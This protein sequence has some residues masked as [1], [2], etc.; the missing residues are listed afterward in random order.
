VGPFYFLDD[1]D[2]YDK[3]GIDQ[4]NALYRCAQ[5]IHSCLLSSSYPDKFC[6]WFWACIFGTPNRPLSPHSDVN[7]EL[8]GVWVMPPTGTADSETIHLQVRSSDTSCWFCRCGRV[9]LA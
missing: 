2:D 6:V 3:V 4:A 1:Y 7:L 5:S 9:R 8:Q